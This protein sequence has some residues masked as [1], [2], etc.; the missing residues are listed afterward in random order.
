M[1]GPLKNPW[2][3]GLRQAHAPEPFFFF[4]FKLFSFYFILKKQNK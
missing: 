3:L 4:F 2:C 1:F